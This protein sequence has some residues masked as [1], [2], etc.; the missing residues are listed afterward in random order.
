MTQSFLVNTKAM[1]VQLPHEGTSTN[2]TGP[3]YPCWQT[4]CSRYKTRI[5]RP[6]CYWWL[7]VDLLDN[8]DNSWK[9]FCASGPSARLQ[10]RLPL[11]LSRVSWRVC[12]N[13]SSASESSLQQ[14]CLM[15]IMAQEKRAVMR[16]LT[17]SHTC[18]LEGAG[19]L[20][21]TPLD[22]QIDGIMTSLTTAEAP[23]LELEMP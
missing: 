16:H 11:P 4:R 12:W 17:K 7:C 8:K 22:F 18:S 10:A 14:C 23:I 5:F 9:S 2:L 20:R 15:K 3:V 1:L 6:A 13:Q 21:W 19:V